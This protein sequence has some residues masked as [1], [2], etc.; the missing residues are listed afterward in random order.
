MTMDF[1]EIARRL[2]DEADTSGSRQDASC[3]QAAA[4]IALAE[5]AR[6]IADA[7]DSIDTVLVN[8]SGPDGAIKTTCVDN[9][10]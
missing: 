7:L 5:Q 1:L 6:R 8:A 9:W 2:L 10:T 4:L 3:A